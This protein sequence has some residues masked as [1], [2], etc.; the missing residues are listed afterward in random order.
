MVIK[1]IDVWSVARMYGVLSGSIGLLGGLCLAVFSVV[2]AGVIGRN[3]QMPGF[4]A[5]AF[6]VG[7]VI[8]LPLLYGVM[9]IIVGALGAVL[10]NLFASLVGGVSVEVE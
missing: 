1:R 3:D 10:Y 5:A 8:I 2:G 6:G 7:A 9:G 4:M